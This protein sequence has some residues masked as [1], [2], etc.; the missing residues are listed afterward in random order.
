MGKEFGQGCV[1]SKTGS[2]VLEIVNTQFQY[3]NIYNILTEKPCGINQILSLARV[4]KLHDR[5]NHFNY[6][7]PAPVVKPRS[8]INSAEWSG[9]LEDRRTYYP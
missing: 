4:L 5:Y 3:K 6:S 7:E 2:I 8:L 1:S 9:D